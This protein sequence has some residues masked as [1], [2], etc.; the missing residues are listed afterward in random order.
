MAILFHLFK[1]L[2]S[3][4]FVFQ[5][6]YLV[7]PRHLFSFVPKIIGPRQLFSFV[8]KIIAPCH[9]FSFVPKIIGPCHL[10]SFVPKIIGP[11]HLFSFVPKIIGPCH[12]FSFVPKIIGPCHLFSFGARDLHINIVTDIEL[13]TLPLP[14]GGRLLLN[15][16]FMH[17]QRM[18]QERQLLRTIKER[19]TRF[20]GHII[21]KGELE[22]LILTG[23]GRG[24]KARGG[25]R[26]LFLNQVMENTG[27]LHP[28]EPYGTPQ[29]IEL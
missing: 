23:K 26:L 3:S 4:Y 29:E 22:D 6:S 24:K 18:G 11:C 25:Q 19:Q 12:R 5:S 13:R 2:V 15:A 9:L 16:G 21:R 8:P 14:L 17:K 28:R 20:T 1:C 7:G 10:F 27:L